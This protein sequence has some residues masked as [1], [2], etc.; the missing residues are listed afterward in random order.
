MCGYFYVGYIDFML[1]SKSL[2]EFTNLFYPN[3]YEQNYKVWQ[4]KT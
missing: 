2:L 3:D 4:K 1:K